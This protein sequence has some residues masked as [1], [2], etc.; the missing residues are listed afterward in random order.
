MSARGVQWRDG[1]YR[2]R[3]VRVFAWA[4]IAATAASAGGA[5]PVLAAGTDRVTITGGADDTAHNYAW[6]VTNR[7]VSPIVEVEFPHYHADTFMVPPGWTQRCTYL[8]NVGVEDRPGVCTAAAP[9]GDGIAHGESAE[10]G[11][12]IC[13][14][15]AN[16]GRGNVRVRFADGSE[17]VVAGVSLPEASP[18]STKY[19]PLVGLAVIFV[20]VV[21]IRERR[22]HR[23][24]ADASGD[25]AGS[26]PQP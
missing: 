21:V 20:L 19:M 6:T 9:A 13:A 23:S 26:P 7:H 24:S 25:T 5:G 11:M 10:F 15:G 12:R 22:R 16:V 17:A 4:W 3:G 1:A 18:T 2:R 8:V 14:A